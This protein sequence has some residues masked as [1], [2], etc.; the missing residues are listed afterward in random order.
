MKMQRIR[1]A[2][3]GIDLHREV[4]QRLDSIALLLKQTNILL[5]QNQNNQIQERIPEVKKK[6]LFSRLF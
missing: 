5:G 6:S 4:T 2:I 1:K 3:S